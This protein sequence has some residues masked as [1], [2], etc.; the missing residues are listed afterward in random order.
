MRL[1]SS[2]RIEL[3]SSRTS[4]LSTV[5]DIFQVDKW[6]PWKLHIILTAIDCGLIPCSSCNSAKAMRCL[7]QAGLVLLRA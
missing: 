4:Y 7:C 1:L 2:L 5:T 6:A 3:S